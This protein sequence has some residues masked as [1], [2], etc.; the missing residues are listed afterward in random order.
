MDSDKITLSNP[1]HETVKIPDWLLLRDAKIEIGKLNATIAELEHRLSECMKLSGSE[2]TKIKG[3]ELYQKQ[4]KE[5]N[6]LQKRNHELRKFNDELLAKLISIQ[7]SL[8]K[9]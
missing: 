1:E 8:K 6:D 3:A 4:K 9:S 5:I 2:K 7:N